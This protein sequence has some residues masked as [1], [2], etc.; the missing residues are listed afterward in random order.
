M[1]GHVRVPAPDIR[2]GDGADRA[3]VAA[4]ARHGR[5][6]GPGGCPRHRPAAACDRQRLSH[7]PA[8]GRDRHLVLRAAVRALSAVV[9]TDRRSRRQDPGHGRLPGGLLVRDVC[10]RVRPEHPGLCHAAVPDRCRRG[11]RH[12][13]VARLHRRHVSLSGSA[14]CARPVHERADD[15]SDCRQHA[16]R[17]LRAVPRLALHLRRL[18]HRLARR[19]RAAGARG[20]TFPTVGDGA[21]A[22]TADPHGAARR[23]ADLRRTSRRAP[24]RVLDGAGGGGRVPA[25]LRAGDAVRRHADT[26]GRRRSCSAR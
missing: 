13:D 19:V 11:G 7:Q 10:L 9:W 14:D 23:F 25:G 21:A 1:M 26:A 24:D 15:R 20:T 12:P 18:R 6:H 2:R 3:R 4:R 16:G 17:R 5:V 22:G 8:G